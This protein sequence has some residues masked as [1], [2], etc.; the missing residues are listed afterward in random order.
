MERE[1]APL[2]T[3][4]EAA[5]TF[6]LPPDRGDQVG[7]LPQRWLAGFGKSPNSDLKESQTLEKLVTV[8]IL[9]VPLHPATG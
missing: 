9:P 6:L 3:H 5:L 1:L 2:A 7:D 4:H 8:F